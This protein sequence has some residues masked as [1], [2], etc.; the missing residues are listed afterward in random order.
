L[1]AKSNGIATERARVDFIQ[2]TARSKPQP[3]AQKIELDLAGAETAASNILRTMSADLNT[4]RKGDFRRNILPGDPWAFLA[5][6]S[7]QLC[8][9]KYCPAH[10]TEF[11][12]E[13]Q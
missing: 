11:C 5:N 2:R 9:A 10:G 13:H 1:I 4:F 12:K 8:S 7:S 6:P 3:P